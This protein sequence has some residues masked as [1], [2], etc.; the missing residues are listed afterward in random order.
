MAHKSGKKAETHKRMLDAAGQN[1]RQFGF[2]GVG[3]DG[4]AKAA[5]V[6]SGAFYAHFGS[7]SAAFDAA[8][9]AGLD[10]VIS[11]LKTF[12]ADNGALWIKAFVDYYLGKPHR[13]NLACSC[14]MATLTSEVIR[15]EPRVHGLYEKK[16]TIIVELVAQGLS[17]SSDEDRHNRAWAMLSILIGGLSV[18]QAMK[19]TKAADEVAS[20]VKAAAIKIAGRAQ[21]VK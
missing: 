12:Q 17:A 6:T 2:S 14:A 13:S 10:E 5:D 19:N 18:T 3:V 21:S 16:M 8:L 11:G 7:K 4:L 15:S 9:E 20:A 1:F